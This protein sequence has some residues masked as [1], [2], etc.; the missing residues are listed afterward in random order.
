MVCGGT[1]TFTRGSPTAQE[2]SSLFPRFK[3][4]SDRSELFPDSTHFDR[5]DHS[6]ETLPLC[7]SS[8]PSIPSQQK[9]PR[10]VLQGHVLM[11]AKP[12]SVVHGLASLYLFT[13]PTALPPVK[14][15]DL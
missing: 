8:E 13:A 4:H 2:V 6:R 1:C 5:S 15:Q 14:V 9:R 10:L 12:S 11:V 7:S 3:P